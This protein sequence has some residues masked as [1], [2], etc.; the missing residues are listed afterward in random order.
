M[1]VIVGVFEECQFDQ[2]LNGQWFPGDWIN[3]VFLVERQNCF[4]FEDIAVG[5]TIWIF[6]WGHCDCT[7]E[8]GQPFEFY[9]FILTGLGLFA[10]VELRPFRVREVPVK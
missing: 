9:V 2:I 7:M 1:V 10:T 5:V 3:F 4:Q 6:E 8:E